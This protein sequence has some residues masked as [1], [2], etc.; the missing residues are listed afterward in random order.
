MGLLLKEGC[1]ESYENDSITFDFCDEIPFGYTEITC[2]LIFNIK[3]YF[4]WKAQH[5]AGVYLTEPPN[6]VPWYVSLVSRDPVRILFLTSSP[7]EIY[8]L[9]ADIRKYFLN[10][11]FSERVCF[12][13]GPEF[14]TQQ[15]MLVVISVHYMA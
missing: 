4:N 3:I 15:N 5:V 2:N 9:D 7:N 1:Q 12:Q 6:N 8:L 14:N 11:G 13:S 10:Y